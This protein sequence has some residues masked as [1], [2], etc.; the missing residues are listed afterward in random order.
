VSAV[1]DAAND[2]GVS[3]GRACD[4]CPA[5]QQ[6]NGG[7]QRRI[8]SAEHKNA[9]QR[10]PPQLGGGDSAQLGTQR[11]THLEPSSMEKNSC[12]RSRLSVASS[13]T[14][15]PQLKRAE[16]TRPTSW[17]WMRR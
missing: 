12:S 14:T 16:P 10:D 15:M 8:P 11:T 1:V 4:S 2:P 7:R 17:L 5:L 6:R 9:D 3:E 13:S